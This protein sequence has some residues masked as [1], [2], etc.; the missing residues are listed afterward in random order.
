MFK[1]YFV[2]AEID[3]INSRYKKSETLASLDQV[4]SGLKA[5]GMSHST[6]NKHLNSILNVSLDDHFLDNQDHRVYVG[7]LI[8]TIENN[9]L[10]SIK[11]NYFK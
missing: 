9:K 6:I 4:V 7:C 11:N 2:K 5:S 1:K 10:V 3:K 8:V